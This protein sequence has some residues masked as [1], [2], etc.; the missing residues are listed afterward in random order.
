[1]LR[2]T[3]TGSD[4]CGISTA[5]ADRGQVGGHATTLLSEGGS[6]QQ[7]SGGGGGGMEK[8]QIRAAMAKE[9]VVGGGWGALLRKGLG[10]RRQMLA[11]E[12]V[13]RR[14]LRRC[15]GLLELGLGGS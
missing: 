8:E 7:R 9:G 4:T 1:M 2:Q 12:K 13:R 10:F 6:G 3:T 11:L 14:V 15:L 5:M